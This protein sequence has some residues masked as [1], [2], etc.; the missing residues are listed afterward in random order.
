MDFV[1]IYFEFHW[2]FWDLVNSREG[3]F[4]GQSYE[5]PIAVPKKVVSFVC[6]IK[7]QQNKAN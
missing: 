6:C 3:Q 2:K 1:A 4:T 7:P 5:C